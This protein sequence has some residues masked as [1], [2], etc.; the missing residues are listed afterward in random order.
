MQR[1]S[2]FHARSTQLVA[3]LLVV[4][5]SATSL[6]VL[7]VF[8]DDIESQVFFDI[9]NTALYTVMSTCFVIFLFDGFLVERSIRLLSKYIGSEFEE[10]LRASGLSI[11]GV[12]DIHSGMP[13]EKLRQC[14]EQSDELLILQTYVADLVQYEV[15]LQK[16]FSRG[17]KARVLLLDPTSNLV[18]IRSREIRGVTPEDFQKSIVQN[19]RTFQSFGGSSVTLRIHDSIPSVSIYGNKEKI[20]VGNYLRGYH[21][22]QGPIIELSH[23]FY[24]EKLLEHFEEI[25]NSSKIYNKENLIDV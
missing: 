3:L 23:S 18:P 7:H 9:S 4:I 14:I 16:F 2:I 20:F 5:A 12:L 22:V 17:G 10:K 11:H 13:Q 6:F 19:I 24:M 21:A 1:I 25:W 8:K 15:S